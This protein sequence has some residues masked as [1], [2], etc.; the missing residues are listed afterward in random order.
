MDFHDWMPGVQSWHHMAKRWPEKVGQKS[1]PPK[2][3]CSLNSIFHHPIRKFQNR[4]FRSQNSS[5]GLYFWAWTP[6]CP[7]VAFGPKN[8]C[9]SPLCPP[10]SMYFN[11]LLSTKVN[12]SSKKK[13]KEK[14][15]GDC[16]GALFF[17]GPPH[18]LPFFS[19][20]SFFCCFC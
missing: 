14:K 19:P 17:L 5:T 7:K 9:F 15:R 11:F 10:S 12:R 16:V 1:T 2:K 13:K 20:S 6:C 3:R 8:L 4:K 18:N